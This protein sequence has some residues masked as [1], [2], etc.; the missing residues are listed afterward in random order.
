MFT[1]RY[2]LRHYIKQTRFVFRGFKYLMAYLQEPCLSV[3]SR[4]AQ[5]PVL[6]LRF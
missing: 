2:A 1:S 3:Q 5:P 6:C 4:I